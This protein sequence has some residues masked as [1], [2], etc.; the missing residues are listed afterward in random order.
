MV[1]LPTS[2]SNGYVIER[3]AAKRLRMA[4]ES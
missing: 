3:F 4:V 2:E 1:L